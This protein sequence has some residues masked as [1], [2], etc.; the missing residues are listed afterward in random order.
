MCAAERTAGFV[1]PQIYSRFKAKDKNSDKIVDYIIQDLP[2]NR[3]KDAV[4][5]MDK[6][7]YQHEPMYSCKKMWEDPEA[8]KCVNE[9]YEDYWKQKVSL[10]CFKENCDEIV[11]FNILKVEEK[12]EVADKSEVRKIAQ[13]KIFEQLL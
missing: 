3:F 11:A 2:E 4:E 1:Y 7:M 13:L 10:V 12:S 8:M 9:L 5:F 6:F